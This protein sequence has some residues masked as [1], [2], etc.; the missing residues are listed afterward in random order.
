MAELNYIDLFSRT[1]LMGVIE[2]TIKTPTFF[3][4]KFFPLF[5]EFDTESCMLDVIDNRDREMAD[6]STEEDNGHLNTAPGFVTEAFIPAYFDERFPITAE[7]LRDRAPG[8]DILVQT[9]NVDRRSIRLAN[10]VRGGL[11][12]IDKRISRREEYMCL[13]ALLTGKITVTT[14]KKTIGEFNF[15]KYLGEDEKPLTNLTKK[16]S[17]SGANPLGDLD[18]VANKMTTQ[19]GHLPQDL[20]L[21]VK[22][23]QALKN[24]LKTPEGHS[25]FDAQHIHVG[26]INPQSRNNENCVQYMGYLTDPNVNI[27]VYTGTYTVNKKVHYFLPEDAALMVASGTGTKETAWR[28]YGAC[29]VA[30]E[31]NKAGDLKTGA[32][33]VDTWYQRDR[34]KGQVIQIQSAPVVDVLDPQMFQVIRGIL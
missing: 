6:F 17:D 16:W 33:I 22:A 4:D 31:K 30:N 25:L 21:G 2:K 8:E 10:A 26:E 15:W 3:R 28:A 5:K 24:Y 27:Y 14:K 23:Y 11:D 29:E 1:T 12:L 7:K 32:R 34:V 19:S 18:I 13:E 20:Y 9:L